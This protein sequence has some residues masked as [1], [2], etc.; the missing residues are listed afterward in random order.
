MP[1]KKK[2]ERDQ[3]WISPTKQR[4]RQY[5]PATQAQDEVKKTP[6]RH[7]RFS[8]YRNKKENTSPIDSASPD[9]TVDT[10]LES[11]SSEEGCDGA[12][13]FSC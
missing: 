4:R 12:T 10:S 9:R 8:L 6:S 5:H 1:R 2:V 3:D 11:S 7:L 13:R